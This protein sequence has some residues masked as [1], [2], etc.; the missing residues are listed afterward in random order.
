VRVVDIMTSNPITASPT[1]S[2]SDAADLM[3]EYEIRHLPVVQAGQLVGIVSDRDLPRP[4]EVAPLDPEQPLSS[5]TT[6]GVVTVREDAPLSEAVNRVLR[7]RVGSLCVVDSEDRLVGILSVIDLLRALR[8][9]D[10]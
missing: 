10:G 5:L 7:K 4:R 9:D 1:D 8:P 6:A 2:L 3:D